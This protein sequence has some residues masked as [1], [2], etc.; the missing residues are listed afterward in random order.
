MEKY[1]LLIDGSSMLVT[2]YYG[3]IPKAIMFAKTE[4]EKEKYYKDILQTPS[5]IYTNAVYGMLRTI[6][7]I[8]KNQKPDYLA[9]AFDKTR[10]TFRR[11]MY[12]G[13]KGNR[14]ATPQ[15]LKEQFIT[16][17]KILQRMGIPVMMS[18]MYEAD[19][20]VAAAA[21]AYEGPDLPVY[22]I[23]KDHDYYQLPDDYVR[24][25]MVQTKQET[26]D[27]MFEE[28]GLNKKECNLPDKTFEYTKYHVKKETGV[29][30]WQIPD[31]KGIIGDTSDNIPGVHGV[32]SAAAPLIAEYGTVEA[33]YEAIEKCQNDKKKLKELNEFWKNSLGISRTPIN[34]LTKPAAEEGGLSAKESAIMSKKLATMCTDIPVPALDSMILNIDD[35]EYRKICEEYGFKTLLK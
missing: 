28:A 33:I 17:E 8:I 27:N 34:A 16:M 4:E 23:T 20:L 26:V 30:P 31:L 7:K 3:N 22:I 14:G 25:W 18:D 21:R 9:V 29:W 13:Y 5:G 35:V 32:S 12:E 10:D 19:D 2:N 11:Q 24:L 15:P 1:L 6:M